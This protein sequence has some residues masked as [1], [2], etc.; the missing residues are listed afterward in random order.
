[1]GACF[2]GKLIIRKGMELGNANLEPEEA[3]DWCRKFSGDFIIGSV[4][5]LE[6][7]QDVADYDY[8]QVDA[9][10]LFHDYLDAVANIAGTLDYDVLGHITYPLKAICEQTGEVL[11]MRRYRGQFR[12]IF[13]AVAGRGKGIEVNTSGLRYRLGRLL[14]DRE[15][16]ELYRSCGGVHITVGSDAHR[17]EDVGEGIV[18]AVECLCTLGWREITVY[19]GRQ[20]IPRPILRSTMRE[21]SSGDC[22]GKS[23]RQTVSSYLGNIVPAVVTMLFMSIY[24]TVDGLFVG[25]TVGTDAMAAINISYPIMNVMFALAFGLASGGSIRIAKALAKE[26]MRR[27]ARDLPW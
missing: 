23:G 1:M 13:E 19:Q 17:P 14:P 24:T 4:H 21:A 22:P 5:N 8:S 25:W 15:L 27:L 7:G 10:M 16:L 20:P 2:Q 11:D 6:P 3:M 18:Q 12:R 26:R 9:G